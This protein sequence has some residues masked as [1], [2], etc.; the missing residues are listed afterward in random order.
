MTS[1]RSTSAVGQAA[2]GDAPD[3]RQLVDQLGHR[4]GD[5][6][7]GR[8]DVVEVDRAAPA[9]GSIARRK[10]GA[11]VVGGD[12]LEQV[13]RE[14]RKRSSS[15]TVRGNERPAAVGQAAQDARPRP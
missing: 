15:P 8:G 13:G 2:E 9:W 4:V 6:E 3:P 5:A 12:A 14:S 11:E 1:S 7:R 10:A